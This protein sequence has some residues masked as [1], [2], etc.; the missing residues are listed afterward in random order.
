MKFKGLKKGLA[1]DLGLNLLSVLFL[2]L[3]KYMLDNSICRLSLNFRDRV[4]KKLFIDL[5]EDI[6]QFEKSSF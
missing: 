6:I 5:S 4:G 1:R 2:W 3:L